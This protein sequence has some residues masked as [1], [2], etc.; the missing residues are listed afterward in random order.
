MESN[1]KIDP[2]LGLF[3]YHAIDKSKYTQEQMA[4]ALDISR[5]TYIAIESGDKDPTVSELEKIAAI[6]GVPLIEL[7]SDERNNRKFLQMYF[8]ILQKF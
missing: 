7:L 4:D 6:F 5:P 3:L 1:R 2:D 8:Y